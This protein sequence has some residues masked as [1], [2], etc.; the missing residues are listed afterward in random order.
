MLQDYF[1]NQPPVL[2]HAMH[3]L[4]VKTDM[5]AFYF[6]RELSVEEA[7]KGALLG[8]ILSSGSAHYPDIKRISEMEQYLY[9]SF[10]YF[11]MDKYGDN[12]VFIY[13][14]IMPSYKIL[15]DLE[16]G[17]AALAFYRSLLHEPLVGEGGFDDQLFNR[18]KKMLLQSLETLSKDPFGYAHRSCVKLLYGDHPLG[19]YKYGS[20]EVIEAITNE[21]L[22]RYYLDLL[23]HEMVFF[24]HH[25]DV[26]EEKHVQDHFHERK[27]KPFHFEG[28]KSASEEVTGSQ[29]IIVEAYHAPAQG[30]RGAQAMLV[31]SHLLGGHANS[32]LFRI[33]RE[34]KQY[35]YSVYTKYDRYRDLIFLTIAFHEGHY[36]DILE[37]LAAILHSVGEGDFSFE[38][39]E[40]A[41]KDIMGTLVS[42]HDSQ[43]SYVEY[44]FLSDYFKRMET[45]GERVQKI[46]DITKEDLISAANSLKKVAHF[47]LKGGR[48]D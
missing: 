19:T 3:K 46:K 37:D 40:M 17:R 8:K 6:V 20:S 35:C 5:L 29:S 7:S 24:Y 10:H 4:S 33:L 27:I 36:E 32:L 21:E 25:G 34:Q 13:K 2:S 44:T 48:D 14:I 22:Y 12:L 39:L 45:I 41:R 30:E 11:D 28:L 38:D 1:L 15:E 26:K 47:H 31:L 43:S 42:L 23:D 9:G 16:T 18:E